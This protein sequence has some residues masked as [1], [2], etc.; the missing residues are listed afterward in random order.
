VLF[1]LCR[2]WHHWLQS[3]HRL[4]HTP[5]RLWP[6]LCRVSFALA[7]AWPAAQAHAGP[8]EAATSVAHAASGVATKTTNAVK[9]GLGAAASGVEHGAK[10]AGRAVSKAA[11]KMGL[12]TTGASAPKP[13][14]TQPP[15]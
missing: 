3:L 11:K 15:P 7:A 5:R 4:M 6:V 10:V 1:S 8:K 14:S 9:R 12:P 13:K 2:A